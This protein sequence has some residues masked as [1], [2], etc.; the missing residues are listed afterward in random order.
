MDEMGEVTAEIEW[1]PELFYCGDCEE[2][3]YSVRPGQYDQ[4]GCGN[5]YVDQT[6]D[7]IRIGGNARPV[8]D[9]LDTDTEEND[10]SSRTI[11]T[12]GKYMA[13]VEKAHGKLPTPPYHHH[14]GILLD[15][16][17]DI[18]DSTVLCPEEAL[19][20]GRW[21]VSFYSDAEGDI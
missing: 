4:C 18:R 7:Y 5:S 20:L 6:R 21:L 14:F 9:R 3:I 16:S 13:K 8:E 2:V 1:K 12:Y 11:N 15:G 10:M 19:R 17:L